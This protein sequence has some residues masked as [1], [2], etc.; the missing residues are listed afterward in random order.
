MRDMPPA[1]R[2][3]KTLLG[4]Y[5][6]RYHRLELEGAEN[7][8]PR[9]PLLIL[10]NHASLLDVP[11][12]MVLDP[13]P[14]TVTVVKA[15]LFNVPVVSW[16]IKQWSAIPV[17]REGR[18]SSSVRA[19]L[20]TLHAGGVVTVAAE[21]RRTRSGRLEPINPVLARIALSADV[22]ILPVGIRG[23]FEA[24][25]PGARLPRPRHIVVRAGRPFRLQRG[26]PVAAAAERIRREIAALLPSEM[27]PLDEPPQAE[28]Q[29][30]D[31]V[32][33]ATRPA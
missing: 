4:T 6:R 31:D 14:D 2:F 19:M 24:L 28:L 18:D 1:R 8:P 15:S 5:M 12:L 32:S 3:I 20:S 23:S 16:F 21:G 13:Y 29:A 9:G 33:S 25:P 27:Q 10:L 11:A 7:L 26:T 30:Y 22:P 17:E